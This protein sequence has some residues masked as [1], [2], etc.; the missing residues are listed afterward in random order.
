[1]LYKFY[2]KSPWL[3]RVLV[4]LW[5]FQLIFILALMSV[6]VW[7]CAYSGFQ[8]TNIIVLI[9][10][11]VCTVLA[12][13]EIILFAATRLHPLIYLILQ[14][15]KTVT[16]LVLFALVVVDTIRVQKVEESRGYSSGISS[17]YLF[18][19]GFVETLVLFLTSLGALIYASVIYHRHRRAKSLF[20]CSIHGTDLY[21][22][23]AD[24]GVNPNHSHRILRAPRNSIK[25]MTDPG[26]ELPV[27]TTEVKEALEVT[28][29]RE[30]GGDWEVYELPATR[31]VRNSK[32]GKSVK[33]LKGRE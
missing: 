19:E 11:V 31:S 21:P 28:V 17:V 24:E 30:L 10:S 15:V 16:W 8:I 14:L 27:Y 5:A 23:I 4:P 3:K 33:S 1:M 12:A 22:V 18:L 2:S 13:T 6:I 7:L 25:E 20:L 29:L 9:I 32:G 26:A